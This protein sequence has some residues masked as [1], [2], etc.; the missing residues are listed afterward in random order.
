MRLAFTSLEDDEKG[1]I[2]SDMYRMGSNPSALFQDSLKL[3]PGEMKKLAISLSRRDGKTVLL[4]DEPTN[5]LDIASMRILERMLR[6]DCRDMTMILV[7][8]DRAFLSACTDTTWKAERNGN[9][10]RIVIT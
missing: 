3:S 8:H 1:L 6:E 9:R 4:M 5:H 2:L 7:S 10:G